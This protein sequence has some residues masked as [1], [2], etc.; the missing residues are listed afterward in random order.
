MKTSTGRND[1]QPGA[2]PKSDRQKAKFKHEKPHSDQSER[3]K[4][5][6]PGVD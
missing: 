1:S 6:N 5:R 2:S 4:K 3:K